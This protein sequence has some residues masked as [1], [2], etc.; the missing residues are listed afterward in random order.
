[1]PEAF[2]IEILNQG[3]REPGPAY[4]P[5]RQDLCTH[6]DL[7]LII[8]GET[9]TDARSEHEYG[10]SE[11]AL[12]LL[13]TVEADHTRQEPVADRLIPHGCGAILMTGCPIGVDWTVLH[14]PRGRV[15]LGGV[16]RYD[17]T[18]E[19]N[20]VQFPNAQATLSEDEYRQKIVAFATL[21]KGPFI[22][23]TKEPFDEV[24]RKDYEDFWVEYD[25]L[26]R[27]AGTHAGG[28]P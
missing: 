21:A 7:R 17:N 27:R 18:D 12:A 11:A 9:I 16:V 14:L 10:I 5:V 4:D 13:R 1:V 24:D 3:W 15:R 25:E 26:L 8:G 20:G 22:G 2:R 19:F 28:H 6:G 23:V